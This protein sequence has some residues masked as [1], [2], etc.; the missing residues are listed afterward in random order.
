MQTS[1]SLAQLLEQILVTE[2]EKI[3]NSIEQKKLLNI[4]L[5]CQKILE[6][7]EKLLTEKIQNLTKLNKGVQ[8]KAR[9]NEIRW[10]QEL[11]LKFV[12]ATMALGLVDVRPK[13]LEIIL[14]Q[15]CDIKLSRLNI[16]S[17][18]QKFRLRVAKQNQIQLAEL[19]NKCFPTDIIHKEL[20][21]LQKQWQFIEFQ[22]IQQHIIIKCLKQLEQ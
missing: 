12:I 13:Q 11:H 1:Q 18:L 4:R 21:Q 8:F 20:S 14:N 9:T 2:D 16:S 10:S 15:C 5:K 19:T 17:H 3:S 7:N 6:K 22:G